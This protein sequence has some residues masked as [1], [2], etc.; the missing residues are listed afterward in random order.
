MRLKSEYENE[1]ARMEMTPL[2]DVVFLLLVFFVYAIVITPSQH[3]MGISLPEAKAESMERH[4][5]EIVLAADG[6]TWFDGRQIE[7]DAITQL[8]AEQP[9]GT[10]VLISADESVPIG[11]G[12][13]LLGEMREASITEV[14]FQTK[15]PPQKEPDL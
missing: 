10:P 7:D 1:S 8:I 6:T 14:A 9:P 5:A 11:R 4:Y 2:M 13:A 15:L 12:L 3:A